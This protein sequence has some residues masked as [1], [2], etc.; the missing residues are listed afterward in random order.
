MTDTTLPAHFS[1]RIPNGDTAE[2]DVCGTC[3]FVLYRNPKVVTGAVVME[4][5][6]VLLCRRAI[7]PRRGYWTLP[8]G[9]MELGETVE[10]AARREAREEA[11]A[12]LAIERVL[13]VYTIPRIAQVQVMF[14]ARLASGG[15]EAGPES[16][17]VDWFGW[18]DIPWHDLAFPSVRW[19]LTQ[20]RSVEGKPDFAPFGNPPGELGD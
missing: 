9:Y 17:E 8:A 1:R 18:D 11:C 7:D 10:E 15:I 13:A 5:G 4:A 16:L 2:R 12:D 19:A 3:G 6:R 14:L 20:A